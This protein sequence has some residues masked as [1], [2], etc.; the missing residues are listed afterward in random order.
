MSDNANRVEFTREMKKDYTII[1]PNMAPIH[2]ELIKNVLE[3]FGYHIDLLRT[4]GR[5]IADEG[6]KYVHNDTCYPALL[7]IGQLMHALHS[8]KYDLHKVALI[9]TQTGGGCRA[10]NY[11]HLLRK[12]LKK[13]GL[14]F[15][16]VISLNLSGLESNSGFKITLPMIR[17]AIAALTYGD[18]LMLLKNQTKPYEVTPGESDAL[19]DSWTNQLTKLFQQ[20]KAFSQREVREYFQK[21]AQS[22]A[23]IKRRDVEKIK[24]GVVGEIYVKYS[25]LANNNLEQF[26]FEQDCEVMVP[27]ILSFMIFKVDNRLEDIRLY[28]GS[29]AK[30][31]VCTLLKWYF[32]KYET[33]LIAAVK[34]FPQFTA[35]APYSHLKELAGKVI[36]Y[37]CKMGEGWLLTAEAMELVE[38]GYG[39]VVCAQPFG[40][41]PNHI[42]GKG[43]IRKVKR[44][45]PQANI[46]PIDYDPSATQVNQENRIKLMLAVAKEQQR[47][48]EEPQASLGGAPVQA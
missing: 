6:L 27:G 28:G 4:T 39:N 30:K 5:E 12:A 10:S 32:T 29:Q 14:D 38:S 33:D 44:L 21:I 31:Q 9:M 16:P 15:I 25:P 13:D 48:Q 42:V 45:Y 37:G 41:L 23:D 20:G 47:D 24:V 35:P 8:G 34:Q 40:C 43:M 11:I 7:S 36:G 2:F 26:L 19:V 18:L 17:Q 46:V 3:S 1:T 22:F